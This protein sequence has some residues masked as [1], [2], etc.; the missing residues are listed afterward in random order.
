MWIKLVKPF[1]PTLL[2]IWTALYHK[3]SML[4]EHYQLYSACAQACPACTY[5]VAMGMGT[6][7]LVVANGHM[8]FTKEFLSLLVVT[9]TTKHVQ[10]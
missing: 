3:H 6:I 9:A 5:Q 7:V 10:I 4:T 1:S 2:K 8:A